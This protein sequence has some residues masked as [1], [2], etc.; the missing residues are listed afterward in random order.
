MLF[1]LWKLF[2]FQDNILNRNICKSVLAVIMKVQTD[3]TYVY[4][5][6]DINTFIYIHMDI[7]YV[8]HMYC[9]FDSRKSC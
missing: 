2:A 9:K 6:A 3:K 1:F 4:L 8:Y 5:F 7:L